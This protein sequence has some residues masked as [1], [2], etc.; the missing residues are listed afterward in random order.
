MH[1]DLLSDIIQQ[2][3]DEQRLKISQILNSKRKVQSNK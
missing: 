2:S 3:N 1:P